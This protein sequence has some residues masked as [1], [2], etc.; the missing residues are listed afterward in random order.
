MTN[1][2]EIYCPIC[3]RLIAPENKTEVESG[4]HDG[5]I[6]VHDAIDHGDDDIEALENGIQ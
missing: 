6:Y 2:S 4:E 1:S 5:F 3:G